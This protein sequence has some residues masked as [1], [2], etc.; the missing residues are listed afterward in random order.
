M[1]SKKFNTF[2]KGLS[3]FLITLLPLLIVS[4]CIEVDAPPE[5][6]TTSSTASLITARY[7]HS[8]ILLNNTKVLIVSGKDSNGVKL[9]DAE[10]YDPATGTFAK[11]N[12]KQNIRRSM[13]SALTT[14]SDG[15]IFIGGFGT[16][17]IYN[18]GSGIFSLTDTMPDKRC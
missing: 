1:V 2:T 9:T 15:T 4:G 3:F 10:I 13:A 8:A 6:K 18:P 17:E 7:Y 16:S 5:L 11:T 12:G 14:L